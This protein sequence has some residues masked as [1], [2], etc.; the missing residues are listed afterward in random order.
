MPPLSGLK[1]LDLSTV[2]AGPSCTRYLADFGATVIKVERPET[3]D[4]SRRMGW[5]SPGGDASLWWKLLSRNKHLITLD[6][7]DP[8]DRAVL[9]DL[10]RDADILVE[11]FRP[12]VM[13]RLGLGP[14]DL[15]A[16]APKL[17]IVR[18]T[19]FGQSGPSSA[20][21]GFG[22]IAEAMSGYGALNTHPDSAPVLPPIALADEFSGLAAAFAALTAV[23]SGR[24]QTVD[25]DLTTCMASILGPITTAVDALGYPAGPMGSQI[26]YSVP[27]NVYRCADGEYIALSG[28]SD[29]M[30][31]NIL[32]MLGVRDDPRFADPAGRHENRGDL[33]ELLGT[34][35]GPLTA[36]DALAMLRDMDIPSAIVQ[37]PQEFL[38]S[39]HVVATGL[40]PR[41]DGLLVAPLIARLGVTP[42]AIRWL[43]GAMDAD[44]PAI[45]R[46]GWRVGEG[47]SAGTTDEIRK[48]AR[49]GLAEELT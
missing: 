12:G 8:G 38:R 39:D 31:R 45:R 33:D 20:E 25:V 14:E 6:L 18:I 4:S 15:H 48:R 26:P 32:E 22:T 21:P 23:R 34:L 42:G 7:K 44:G 43:G 24:G 46:S 3:G 10:V 40:F 13:A 11:S 49:P 16:V 17:A 29:S 37:T 9:V 35:I 36:P 19:G 27:R 47:R 28:A 41:I 5:L 2:I 30:V 1:V